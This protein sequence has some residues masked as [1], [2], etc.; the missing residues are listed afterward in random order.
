M[1]RLVFA[2]LAVACVPAA[3]EAGLVCTVAASPVQFGSISGAS[4]GTF[5]ARGTF[6]VYCTGTQGANIAAC[7]EIG[8]GAALSASGQ[9]T[10]SPQKGNGAI[11]LQIFQD[12]TLG[13]PWG[14]AARGQALY[15]Q[16]TGDGPLPA[17]AYLRAYVQKGAAG[18][19]TYSAQFPV[20]LRYG[21]VSGP[22]ADCNAL[23]LA[24]IPGGAGAKQTAFVP[25]SRSR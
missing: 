14:S 23:G 18:P 10:V 20:T 24:A 16:R 11:G 12:A 5:D 22:F 4:A 8:D 19:G 25:R 9:R 21:A 17:T 15:L 6:T 2:L 13:R 3:A 1:K 7:I